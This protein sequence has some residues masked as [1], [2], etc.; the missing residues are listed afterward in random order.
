MRDRETVIRSASRVPS[1]KLARPSSLY[2]AEIWRLGLSLVRVLPLKV[3][4]WV[5]HFVA[6]ACWIIAKH[7]REIIIQNV[8]PALAGDTAS[9]RKTAAMKPTI[10]EM[11]I[12]A[13]V[14]STPSLM[15]TSGP[16]LTSAAPIRPPMSA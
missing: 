15:M 4:V 10:G 5:S 13:L 14:L 12:K 7:R 16:A 11:T 9:A 2:R 3:C 6:D 1:S 8:S